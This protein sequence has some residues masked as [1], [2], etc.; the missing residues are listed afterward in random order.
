[1]TREIKFR[2]WDKENKRMWYQ[3]NLPNGYDGD[4]HRYQAVINKYGE[5]SVDE[6]IHDGSRWKFV[7]R[8][9]TDNNELIMQYIGL[10]DKNGVDIYEGDIILTDQEVVYKKEDA[11]FG[12]PNGQYNLG[13]YSDRNDFEVIGNI[14]QNPEL[15][16]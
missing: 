11:M 9:Y 7:N 14:Y 16:Q 15:L 8:F 6:E 13:N 1:M 2:A 10:K 4:V 5:F 3:D 12:I